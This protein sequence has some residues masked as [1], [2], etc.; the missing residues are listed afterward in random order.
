MEKDYIKIIFVME[1]QD[2]TIL[3]V[4]K[5]MQVQAL[6]AL[7][8]KK[9]VE[10]NNIS[11]FQTN[12]IVIMIPQSESKDSIEDK[13]KVQFFASSTFQCAPEAY[14]LPMPPDDFLL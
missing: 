4:N 1:N 13:S 10:K 9:S 14:M 6:L 11:S 8:K 5:Q 12:E 3:K 7:L 2:P